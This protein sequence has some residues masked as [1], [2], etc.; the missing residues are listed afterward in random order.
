MELDE[1]MEQRQASRVK[2]AIVKF[3]SNAQLPL[4]TWINIPVIKAIAG[5]SPAIKDHRLVNALQKYHTG[6]F[7]FDTFWS[8]NGLDKQVT[9]IQYVEFSHGA[10]A[11]GAG[12][13]RASSQLHE[14]L[15]H[16][17][18]NAEPSPVSAVVE[19]DDKTHDTI[20]VGQGQANNYKDQLCENYFVSTCHYGKRC[21]FA[22]SPS[23]LHL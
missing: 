10:P 17:E 21:K 6:Q 11:V 5:I 2:P 1:V 18:T 23:E 22:H 16:T 9:C 4:D 14:P 19:V 15:E 7:K 20:G 8:Q 13:K 12:T 3:L